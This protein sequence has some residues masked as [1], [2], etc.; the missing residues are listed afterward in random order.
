VNDDFKRDLVNKLLSM[1]IGSCFEYFNNDD[2]GFKIWKLDNIYVLFEYPRFGGG[3][4]Y[5][6][7]AHNA[8]SAIDTV[9]G[10]T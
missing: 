6:G 3:P 1:K 9:L 7:V 8:L 2:S 5:N 4:V 10:W